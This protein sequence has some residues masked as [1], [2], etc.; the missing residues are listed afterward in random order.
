MTYLK[1]VT[2]P[3]RAA[4]HPLT[5]EEIRIG[6]G[7]AY[8][9]PASLQAGRQIDLFGSRTHM[10]IESNMA[11]S[12]LLEVAHSADVAGERIPVVVRRAGGVRIH[13]L[14]S[15]SAAGIDDPRYLPPGYR[16]AVALRATMRAAENITVYYMRAEAEFDG[17]GIRVVQTAPMKL[18]PPSSEEFLN[19]RVD[20]FAARWSVERGELEWL[21][22]TTYRA[23]AV[24]SGDLTTAVAIARSL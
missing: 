7:W 21:D 19:V 2:Q 18:L 8:Y 6:A 16:R 9:R 15:E 3:R 14:G 4:E 23:V 20:D 17:D 12:E 1:V 5:A 22:G 11:R 10:R 13:R 24:P